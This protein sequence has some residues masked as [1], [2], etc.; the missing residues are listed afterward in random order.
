MSIFM[1]FVTFALLDKILDIMKRF[2]ITLILAI[3]AFVGANAQLLYK[4]SGNGLDAPSYLV[5]T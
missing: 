2:F 4:I 3:V 1:L 5:G